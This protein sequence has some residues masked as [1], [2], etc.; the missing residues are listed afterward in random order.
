MV[1]VDIII[2]ILMTVYV[3]YI[4]CQIKMMHKS[5]LLLLCIMA[6]SEEEKR[7]KRRER[8]RRRHAGSLG[9]TPSAFG[10]LLNALELAVNRLIQDS[11]RSFVLRSALLR[12]ILFVLFKKSGDFQYQRQ[13]PLPYKR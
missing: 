10:V 1:A 8:N 2:H 13:H 9:A 11:R 12:T 7:A 4:S 6:Q 5:V 3:Y